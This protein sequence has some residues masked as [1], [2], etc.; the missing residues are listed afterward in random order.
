MSDG[1]PSAGERGGSKTRPVLMLALLAVAE[2]CGMAAW[3]AGNA[4]A[5]ELAARFALSAT[6]Q[7][8]LTSAVQLGFV[9]GTLAAA[10]LNLPDLVPSRWYLAGAA[11]LAAGAN[12]ALLIAPTFAGVLLSRFGLGVA[13][14][15]VYPPAM[16][17]AATWFAAGRGLAIGVVVASLTLG[18]AVPYLVEGF[19]AL[20]LESVVRSTSLAALVAAAAVAIWYRDGPHAFAR[21]PFSWR[22]VGEVI[23]VPPLRLVTAG[24]LGHMW[25][26]YAYW[27]YVGGYWRESFARSGT[28]V[29]PRPLAVL[30][31][32]SIAIGAVGCLWGGFAAD[33]LGRARVVIWA[34]TASA[35]AGIAAG[36]VIDA[37][38]YL[39]GLVVAVWGIAIIADSAQFSALATEL[40]PSHAVGTALTLQ[41]S[42]GFLLTI[43]SIQ[44]IGAIGGPGNRWAFPLLAVGPSLGILAMRRLARGQT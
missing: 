11:L 30:T 13:L 14:A 25:E 23:R 21:R 38:S 43:G 40:A 8:W 18:K 28:A 44:L 9:A 10:V 1:R 6:E 39:V 15:G 3:F 34:L 22:L 4:V 5:P 41:T 20:G 19:G 36:L 29:G 7:A 12:A 2:T 31:F 27:T 37:P 17:M 26:L 35:V 42:I 32:A 16:K 33:R 24:Y